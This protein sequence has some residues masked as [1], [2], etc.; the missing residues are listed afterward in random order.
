M[1]RNN[2]ERPASRQVLTAVGV[3]MKT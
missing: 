3:R 2:V 1:M